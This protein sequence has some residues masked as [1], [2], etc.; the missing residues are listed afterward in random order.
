MAAENPRPNASFLCYVHSAH[1][2]DHHRRQ[3]SGRLWFAVPRCLI[4]ILG[5]HPFCGS[6]R[7]LLRCC[8]LW[9]SS[10]LRGVTRKVLHYCL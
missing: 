6:T 5:S 1:A 2:L 10:S 3:H 9:W 7:W 4:P 8:L